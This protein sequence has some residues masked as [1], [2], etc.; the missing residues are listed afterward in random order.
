MTDHIAQVLMD[1]KRKFNALVMDT[2][3]RS[4]DTLTKSIQHLAQSSSCL[5]ESSNCLREVAS[6]L[7]KQKTC[8]TAT[9]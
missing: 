3:T 4:N 6:E 5:L 8:E 9:Q 7:Q 2:L 1:E